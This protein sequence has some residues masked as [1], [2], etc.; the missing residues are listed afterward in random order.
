MRHSYI[1]IIGIICC[2]N[3]NAQAQRDSIQ[4]LAEVKLVGDTFKRFSV[5]QHQFVLTDSIINTAS[6]SLTDILERHTSIY[7]KQNGYGMI[8]SPSFRGTT[9]Q[10]TAVLWNGININSQ[11]NAQSDF[12]TMNVNLFDNIAVRP[13]GGSVLYGSGAIGGSVHLNDKLRFDDKSKHRLNLNVGSFS[14]YQL[15]Y[16]NHLSNGKWTW[17]AGLSIDRSENDYPFPDDTRDNLNGKFSHYTLTNAL[18]YKINKQHRIEL[19]NWFY[20]GERNLALIRPSDTRQQYRN[21]DIRNLISWKWQK[22]HFRSVLSTAY[23]REDFE[24]IENIERNA[25]TYGKVDRFIMRYDLT[26]KWDELSVQSRFNY[27]NSRVEGT[28]LEQG[29][30]NDT[31]L[32][33][34][35]NYELTSNVETLASLRYERS[36][37]FESPLLFSLGTN[38]QATEHYT[39]KIDLSR[40]FRQPSFNDLLWENSGNQELKAERSFQ[41]ETG[42]QFQ[43]SDD[44]LNITTF[45]NAIDDMIQWLPDGSGVW[46]PENVKQ[47]HTYGLELRSGVA[48]DIAERTFDLQMNYVWTRSIDETTNKQMIYV[49]EHSADLSLSTTIDEWIIGLSSHYTGQ[50]YARTDHNP[51]FVVEDYWLQ[52]LFI[53]RKI[54]DKPLIKAHLQINN[55]ANIRYESVI[56]RP[57]PGINFQTGIQLQL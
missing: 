10:Q 32:S 29:Q 7:F 16:K 30:R 25:S 39:L 52:D 34:L 33:L 57:M 3:F 5:G 38:W 31:S 36:N 48:L 17:D 35:A 15:A 41:L 49:P 43:W 28:Q 8:S 4:Q 23:L 18:G 13:G 11:L 42:H 56:N 2:L 14:S 51:D 27:E 50:V 53:R 44:E 46:R 9:A 37:L 1:Y 26:Y 54:S 20:D 24:F 55:L 19:H 40:N 22:D 47:V 6:F 12:N 45:Y 21:R